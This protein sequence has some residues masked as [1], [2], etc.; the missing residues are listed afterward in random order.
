MNYKI[1]K[2]LTVAVMAALTGSASAADVLWLGQN[3]NSTVGALDFAANYPGGVFPSGADI[4][5]IEQA[6][7]VWIGNGVLADIAVRVEGGGVNVS[8]GSLNLRGGSSGSGIT[9][10]LE[11][12][13]TDYDSVV[14]LNCADK[15][16]TLWSRFGEPISLNILAG[17]VQV[18]S[19]NDISGAKGNVSLG[20]GLFHVDTLIAANGNYNML[21]GGTGNIVIDDLNGVGLGSM[22]LYFGSGNTGSFTFGGDSGGSAAGTWQAVVGSIT[23]E[24]VATPSASDFLITQIGDAATIRLMPA[25]VVENTYLGVGGNM[26]SA[27]SWSDGVLPGQDADYGLIDGIW[28]DTTE[29]VDNQFSNQDI[30]QTGGS[31]SGPE[32][33]LQY[34]SIYELETADT[35]YS[36]VDLDVNGI[37][38]MWT[39]NAGLADGLAPELRILNGRIDIDNLNL[40]AGTIFMED[41]ELNIA[42]INTF[43]A[44]ASP[45]TMMDGGSG[46]V[47]IADTSGSTVRA[48]F[49]SGNSGSITLGSNGGSSAA[50]LWQI[51]I[52]DGKIT[53]EGVATPA[54]SDFLITQAG[55]AATI[56]LMPISVV[57]NT[58]LGGNMSSA[59]SW[60]YGVQPGQDADYGLIDGIWG[61]TTET[62]DNVF[63]NQDIRQT[64]G[65]LS[66]PEAYLQFGSIYELETA[67]TDYSNVDLDV[68]GDFTMWSNNVA[69][70]LRVLNGRIDIDNLKLLAGT[71]SMRD[72]ELNIAAIETF[73]PV[74]SPFNMLAGGSGV[75]TFADNS[76]KTI[77]ANFESNNAGSIVLGDITSGGVTATFA[78]D[79]SGSITLGDLVAPST[80]DVS[81]G[82]GS[83]ASVVLD[84]LQNGI[85]L[86]NFEHGSEASFTL[87]SKNSGTNAGGTWQY[88]INNTARISIAGVS[89][90]DVS[91]FVI[92]SDGGTGTTISLA[93]TQ[94]F[95]AI[96]PYVITPNLIPNGDFDQMLN[97]VGTTNENGW[98]NVTNSFGTF[99]PF[100]DTYV[101][102]AD[103]VYSHED[104][105]LLTDHLDA[106]EF[107]EDSFYIDA[108]ANVTS[109]QLTFNSVEN[110]RHIMTQADALSAAMIDAGKTYVFSVNAVQPQNSTNYDLASGTLTAV[111][112][113]SVGTPIA[114]ATVASTLDTWNGVQDVGISGALLNIGQVDVKFEVIGTNA[115]P[116]YD[117][118]PITNNDGSIIAKTVVN[119]ISLFELIAPARVDLN[120][121]GV[122]DQAD[123]DLANSYLD[124]SIDG[125]QDAAMRQADLVAG[126]M[127]AAEALA[128]LN[129]TALDLDG[130]DTF[131]AA[132]VVVLELLLFP[133]PLVID[134]GILNGSGDFV[135]Q[136]SDLTIG[137]VYFLMKDT[138]LSDG[139]VFNVVADSVTAAL[140]TETLTDVDAGTESDKAFYQVTDLPPFSGF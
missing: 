60:S 30:R 62:V 86:V 58:Y 95:P 68:N 18:G 88:W 102:V 43:N 70:E 54:A 38:T 111:L 4:G 15:Q 94:A 99:L 41:G 73:N 120:R 53:I 89:S 35:D 65:S 44:V 2:L 140:S 3:G 26:N 37:F 24:G 134:S 107:F 56:R 108:L 125:G 12:D 110:F 72:G 87:S 50:G 67:D 63:S 5:V 115:I 39:N 40:L 13:T 21:A 85:V 93:P 47:T 55:D 71:I 42:A 84:D 131:D 9:T 129:L 104:P 127:T 11:F 90:S 138:D 27:A 113:D 106:G 109:K 46:S 6:D 135:V 97:L 137:T 83:S 31:L 14:N 132:D 64:G 36:N 61:D 98:M 119:E 78:A 101:E 100:Q 33:Y 96:L 45:I 75:V 117:E 57:E 74:A 32:A 10:I 7:N 123:V 66:G 29:T 1:N 124:G 16:L 118:G 114:G 25:S 20:D 112:T 69:P 34:D 92:T 103:W 126:G 133:V 48:Y 22:S 82:S 136:V 23:I 116:N 19:L 91:R 51:L 59:A 52:T 121:D 105:E 77:R 49:E 76:A 17:Q 128:Y 122:T 79:S 139:A 28:G 8:S 80:V 130:D 81:F